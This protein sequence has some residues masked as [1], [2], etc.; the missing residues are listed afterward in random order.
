MHIAFIPAR[1]GSKG[2]KHKNRLFFDSTANF[3][4]TVKWFDDVI[5]STD[6][7]V[8]VDYA[9]KRSYT[10][11]HRTADLSGAAVSIK[12]VFENLIMEKTI[13][14]DTIL[15]LFY[16]PIL[17]KQK[18]DFINAKP[19]IEQ[20]D[21][22]SLCSFI[23][24]PTHPYNCWKYDKNKSELEQYIPNDI[25]RRQDLDQAWMQYHYLYCFKVA[26]LQNLN[27][28]MVNKKTHPVFLNK[29]T[30]DQLVEV[31]TPED[32]EKWKK[33]LAE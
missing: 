2:F 14:P 16:L 4:D 19:I 17:F 7:P 5:V 26:E 10:I 27:S 23:P 20:D 6:D 12:Q 22:A 15:W 25:F 32:Y 18:T 9:E 11:H 1:E 24:A 3:L 8:I 28:E 30:A 13:E 31:D 29:K 21:V 33:M